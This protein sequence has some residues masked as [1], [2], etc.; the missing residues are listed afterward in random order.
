MSLLSDFNQFWR[1]LTDIRKS[2]TSNI[3]KNR[4]VG[5]ALIRA[6]RQRGVEIDGYTGRR[7]SHFSNHA[8]MRNNE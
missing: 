4:P 1:L 3:M 2:P 5:T 8:K 6:G 7:Y